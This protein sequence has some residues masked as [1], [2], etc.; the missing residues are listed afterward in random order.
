MTFKHMTLTCVTLFGVGYGAAASASVICGPNGWS[1]YTTAYPCED[2]EV[3]SGSRCFGIAPPAVVMAKDMKSML[4]L[5]ADIQSGK[6]ARPNGVITGSGVGSEAQT[7][8]KPKMIVIL[9]DPRA[10]QKIEN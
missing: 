1:C 6:V 10:A 5:D 7:I 4:S 3:P 2:L 8:R 9:P